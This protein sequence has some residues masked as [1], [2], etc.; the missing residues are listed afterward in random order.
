MPPEENAAPSIAD[1][2]AAAID[3]VESSPAPAADTG[4]V[5]AVETPPARTAADPATAAPDKPGVEGRDRAGRFT[6]KKTDAAHTDVP[7]ADVPVAKAA[8]D[9]AAALPGAVP[10]KEGT[11]A[12]GAADG[13]PQSWRDDLKAKWAGLDPEVRGEIARREREITVGLQRAAETRKF[14]DAIAQEF[15]PYAEILAKEGATPQ[16]AIRALLETSYTLSG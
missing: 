1:S 9:P 13:A 11:P 16:A 8:A 3:T 15:A 7:A 2:L 14:G 4:T 5:A 6:P 12:A 10:A